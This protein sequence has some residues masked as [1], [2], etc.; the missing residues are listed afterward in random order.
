[1][2]DRE[3]VIKGLETCSDVYYGADGG[4]SSCPY[5]QNNGD[6]CL[7]ELV[8]DA[9]ELLKEQDKIVEKAREDGY[10][11]GYRAHEIEVEENG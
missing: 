3:K 6:R 7:A 8:Y 1:M 9:I 10:A 11:D 2:T 4:C 5:S